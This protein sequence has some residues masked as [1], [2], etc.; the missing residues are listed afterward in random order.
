MVCDSDFQPSDKIPKISNVNEG[1]IYF[2]S[3]FR[4]FSPWL[5]GPV[6]FGLTVKQPIMAE[7]MVS[8]CLGSTE[9]Q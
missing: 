6:D 4:G 1:K 8:W 2:C 7:A 5:V 9:R 3:G